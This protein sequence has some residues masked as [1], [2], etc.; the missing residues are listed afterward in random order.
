MLLIF[1]YFLISYTA[2]E[3][4]RAQV[5]ICIALDTSGSVCSQDFTNPQT[6]TDCASECLDEGFDKGTC[7]ENF[8]AVEEFSVQVMNELTHSGN[9]GTLDKRKL[10]SNRVEV[11]P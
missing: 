6:C 7:C 3:V 2:T 9:L 4:C 5:N 11:Y 1:L 8:R 10:R